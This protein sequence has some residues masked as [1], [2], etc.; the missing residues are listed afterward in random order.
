MNTYE[1]KT[2]EKVIKAESSQINVLEV[3]L[4]D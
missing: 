2:S 3:M 1:F 4:S